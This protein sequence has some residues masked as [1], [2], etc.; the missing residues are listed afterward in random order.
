MTLV[1]A[2][3]WYAPLRHAHMALVG[4]SVSLFLLRGAAVLA[5]G[6]TSG[7]PAWPG[8][9]AAS[10]LIDSL[11]LSSGAALWALLGL[12]PLQHSWLGTKLALL[13]AY[14]VLGTLAL[15]RARSARGRALA[16]AGALATV[17][18]M[19]AVAMAHHPLGWWQW[20][21]G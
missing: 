4:L 11:L 17:A 15:K 8:L 14:I 5:R 21:R 6:R 12:H 7:W 2:G 20:L 13:L 10:V 18:T 19:A 9:R 16:F 1:D 3:S